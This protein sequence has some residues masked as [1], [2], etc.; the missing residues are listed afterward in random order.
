MEKSSKLKKRFII[1]G[2]IGSIIVRFIWATNKKTF[3]G[4]QNYWSKTADG[5]GV[6]VAFWHNQG[7][8]MPLAWKGLWCRSRIIVSRSKDGDLIA[9]LL[10]VFGILCVR[11]SSTRGGKEALSDILTAG[12]DPG[13]TLVITPDGPKGPAGMVKEGVAY[14]AL[15]TGRPLYCL[16]VSYTRAHMFKSW[17][18]FLLPWPFGQSFFVCRGPIFLSGGVDK[19]SRKRVGEQIQWHLDRVNEC[20][21]ALALGLADIKTVEKK[22]QEA[23]PFDEPE[24]TP[25]ISDS[26]AP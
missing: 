26:S 18:G 1:L 2:L 3:I 11:G 16:S 22:L 8:F 9:G 19:L 5:N 7:L 21:R 20:S 15:K 10:R 14:L 24:V 12:S 6:L 25:V 4:F 17:D 23:C 13:M